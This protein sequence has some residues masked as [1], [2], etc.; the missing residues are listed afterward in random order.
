MW[1]IKW[2]PT[3][4]QQRPMKF[5]VCAR[6]FYSDDGMIIINFFVFFFF[7]FR[8][9]SNWGEWAHCVGLRRCSVFHERRL[10]IDI[11]RRHF[12]AVLNRKYVLCVCLCLVCDRIFFSRFFQFLGILSNSP[13][14]L[15]ANLVGR[16]LISSCFHRWMSCE[17]RRD[18]CVSSE[19][20]TQWYLINWVRCHSSRSFYV[21][22]IFVS[23]F[24]IIFPSSFA[25]FYD[26][27]FIVYKNEI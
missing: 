20:R 23:S 13:F 8:D 10:H 14:W 24:L 27:V 15:F 22:F 26:C 17:W 21:N 1:I 25:L 12:F 2:K 4:H 11:F 3:E 16:F 19:S 7:L 5:C 6:K 9:S 18:W